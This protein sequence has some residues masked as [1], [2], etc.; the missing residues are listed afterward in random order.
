MKT[1]RLRPVG[2][3]NRQGFTLIELLV[4]IAIIGI[5]IALLLPAV[6]QSRV[7]ARR[8]QSTN[9]LKQLGLAMHNFH[10]T[11]GYLPDNGTDQ[12][13]WWAWGPPWNQNAIRPGMVQSGGWIYKIL[14]FIDQ[15][16]L[17]NNWQFGIPVP[18]II[19]PDRGANGVAV[20]QTNPIPANYTPGATLTWA[21]CYQ[22]GPVTDYAANM[23]VI[24]SGMNT[25]PLGTPQNG[26]GQW[27]Q[28]NPELWSRYFR[29]LTDI[30]D[31]T[32]NTV[33][34]G[35][36][37]MATETYDNRGHGDH[38]MP[39]GTLR[40]KLDTPITSAGVWNSDGTFRWFSSDEHQ[41]AADEGVQVNP[42]THVVYTNYIPGNRFTIVSG[43][44][45]W[46]AGTFGIE[47]DS[48]LKDCFNRMGSSYP[49]GAPMLMAD[50]SVKT[51]AYTISRDQRIALATPFGNDTPPAF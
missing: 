24:G 7:A 11:Y 32:S 49:G 48:S 6:Q 50:G 15:I 25:G 41:N 14:P 16:G 36:K 31:G 34:V 45:A 23:M 4:V 5:L 1:S 42:A 2:R 43:W 39:N 40:G 30:K 3:G 20:S 27:N 37:A 51:L 29:K 18:G 33:L 28:G 46:F 35:T 38:V 12:Y 13:T 21:Q 10:D 22:N 44:S 9:N 26:V 19:D 8:T 17:Y 47:Q